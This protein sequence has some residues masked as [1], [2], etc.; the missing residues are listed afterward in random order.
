MINNNCRNVTHEHARV[1]GVK[2]LVKRNISEFYIWLSHWISFD[3]ILVPERTE[4]KISKDETNACEYDHNVVLVLNVSM[5]V[6][7]TGCEWVVTCT[8]CVCVCILLLK[9]VVYST[10]NRYE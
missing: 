7:L 8:M 6:K 1:N 2:M 4:I 10:T 3:L 5:S 9:E